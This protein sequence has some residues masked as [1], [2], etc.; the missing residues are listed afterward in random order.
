[1]PVLARFYGITVRMYFRGSEHNPPHV[2]ALYG[3]YAAAFDLRT[4]EIID[5]DIPP[6]RCLPCKRVDAA[7]SS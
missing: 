4:A 6:A 3:D 5:G 1:M 7:A 2:H